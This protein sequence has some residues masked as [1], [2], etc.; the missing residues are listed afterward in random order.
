MFEAGRL[1]DQ[2][3]GF[4]GF[5]SI[6][7]RPDDLGGG[8]TDASIVQSRAG[9]SEWARL[10]A[11]RCRT[12]GLS[13]SK[14][15]RASLS[16][17]LSLRHRCRKRAADIAE[18]SRTRRFP[19]RPVPAHFPL[20]RARSTGVRSSP[21]RSRKAPKARLAGSGSRGLAYSRIDEAAMSASRP[22][23]AFARLRLRVRGGRDDG[24]AFGD[25]ASVR[26]P[27]TDLGGE[28]VSRRLGQDGA[29]DS[30]G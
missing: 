23:T 20:P 12:S 25:P 14:D 16:P 29:A 18:A 19:G 4:Q 13:R 15:S 1:S 28:G 5:A 10:A 22:S 27:L 3:E 21:R 8:I 30:I 11:Q 6:G 17:P 24:A 9:L 2:S 26:A 7:A